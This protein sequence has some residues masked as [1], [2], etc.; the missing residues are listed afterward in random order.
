MQLRKV[1]ADSP[2]LPQVERLYERAF[3]ANERW[4]MEAVLED[5]TGVSEL[6]SFFDGVTFCG[7]IIM[8]HYK[9]LSHIIY[10][11]VEDS[12]RSHGYGSEAL[13]LVRERMPEQTIM[14]DIERETTG[15]DN[16][17]QRRRRKAFYLR[18]GYREAGVYYDWRGESYE[19][20]ILGGE[21]TTRE[22]FRFWHNID[23]HSEI[24]GK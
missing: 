3:P 7:F 2:E 20:V 24:F 13:R 10:F 23:E 1:T 12:L 21:I 11:A 14:V 9:N 15:A 4:G 16:N 18:N 5:K 19:I 17:D 22:Y 6:L 8:L